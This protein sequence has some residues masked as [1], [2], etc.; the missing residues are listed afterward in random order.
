MVHGLLTCCAVILVLV[1]AYFLILGNADRVFINHIADY[2]GKYTICSDMEDEYGARH[3]RGGELLTCSAA[4]W[5]YTRVFKLSPTQSRV[6]RQGG[7]GY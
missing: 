5:W 2:L 3:V 6:S 7:E 4:F 1:G